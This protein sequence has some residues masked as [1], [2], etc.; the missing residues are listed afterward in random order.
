MPSQDER[1]ALRGQVSS[2]F[3]IILEA[4]HGMNGL[5][6]HSPFAKRSDPS[7]LNSITMRDGEVTVLDA[8]EI[9]IDET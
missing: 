3:P 7:Y 8:G 4:R 2:C 6:M 9:L 5:K 1:E